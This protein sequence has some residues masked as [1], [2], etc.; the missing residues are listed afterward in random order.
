MDSYL[1]MQK[2]RSQLPPKE[3]FS[4]K[5]L[6]GPHNPFPGREVIG[7]ETR[8]GMP[9]PRKLSCSTLIAN[10]LFYRPHSLFLL[11]QYLIESCL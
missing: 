9:P 5:D 8:D 3:G 10:E 11:P 7:T 6:P 2:D 4:R 1:T